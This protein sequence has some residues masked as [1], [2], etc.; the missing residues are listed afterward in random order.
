VAAVLLLAGCSTPS[1][2]AARK[3][4]RLAVFNAL[5][6]DQQ[7]KIEKGEIKVGMPEEAVYIAWGPPDQILQ[8]E[9]AQ[10][11]TKVW[12][13]MGQWMEETRYWTSSRASHGGTYPQSDYFPRTYA[14]AELVFQDG[15]LISWRTLPK[16]MN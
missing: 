8:N 1:T 3:Q 15:K 13:Y 9:T 5:P 7:Q 14:S 12:V 16:P 2:I 11:L 4:E 6:P 10:G